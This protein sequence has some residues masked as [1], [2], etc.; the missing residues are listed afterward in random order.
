MTDSTSSDSQGSRL[1]PNLVAFFLALAL[2]WFLK[3]EPTDLVW[4]LWLGSLVIGYATVLVRIGYGFKIG[5]AIVRDDE[6]EGPGKLPA[7]LIGLAIGLFLLGFFSLHFCGF[8]AG[9]SAFLNIFFPLPDLPEMGFSN[10]FMNPFLLWKQ[11]FQYLLIPYGLFLIP[12]LIVERKNLLKPFR[13]DL[14]PEEE[15]PSHLEDRKKDFTEDLFAG[16]Y[17]N[18]IRMHLLIFFFAGCHLLK[19]DSFV[20]Y[21]VV[22]TV[23]FFPWS[24]CKSWWQERSDSTR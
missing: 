13:K 18:V 15:E 21:A 11:V 8:H 23:Y 5:W 19:V 12:A 20:I 7:I 16:P 17:K 22:S 9:H 4:S 10:A 14:S 1:I 24:E 2:A 6:F 3:W